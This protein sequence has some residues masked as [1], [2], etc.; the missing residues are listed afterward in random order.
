MRYVGAAFDF[1]DYQKVHVYRRNEHGIFLLPFGPPD[2]IDSIKY[3]LVVDGLWIA[4]PTNPN[5]MT[6]E[7]GNTLS[8]LTLALPPVRTL[9]SPTLARDGTIEF[10]IRHKP[11]SKVFLTGDFTNWEPFMIQMD[12]R[13]EGIYTISINLA[14][15]NYEYCFIVDG[16]RMLDPLNHSYGADSHGY[17]ASRFIV[18]RRT[19]R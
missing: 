13:T 15:G 18:S 4:D 11:D 14:P 6:D 16:L 2:T 10:S 7:R 17:L 5:T 12:E 9:R 19:S 3:R 8:L 1:E